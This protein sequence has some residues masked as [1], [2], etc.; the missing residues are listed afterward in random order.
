MR[1]YYTEFGTIKTLILKESI[2]TTFSNNINLT[3]ANS[4]QLEQ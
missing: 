2:S 4:P 1:F 3:L